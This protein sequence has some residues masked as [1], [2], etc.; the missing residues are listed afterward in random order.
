MYYV[1]LCI[2][3]SYVL[4][5]WLE[6]QIVQVTKNMEHQFMSVI[7]EGDMLVKSYTYEM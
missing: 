4:I 3:M 6:E 2:I 7:A 1:L 5:W